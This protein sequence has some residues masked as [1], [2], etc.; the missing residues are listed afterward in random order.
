M[1]ELGGGMGAE[2]DAMSSDEDGDDVVGVGVCPGMS[3][4]MLLPGSAMLDVTIPLLLR[5]PFNG[6]GS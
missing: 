6:M 4:L 2:V 5:S 1:G 3:T